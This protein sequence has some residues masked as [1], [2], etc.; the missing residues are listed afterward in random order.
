[1]TID[2]HHHFWSVARGDYDWLADA[3]AALRRNFLP[4]DVRAQH[5]ALGIT[6]SVL[7]QAAPTL[8]ET[9]YLLALAAAVPTVCGVVGWIDMQSG[10]ALRQ[11][12][13]FAAD[14][15]FRGIRPML[16]DLADLDW[17]ASEALQP[18]MAALIDRDLSFDA[19]VRADQFDTVAALATAY[20]ELR[21]ILD[22][23]GKPPIASGAPSAWRAALARL[24]TCPNVTCKLSGL[25]TE[26]AVGTTLDDLAP[27]AEAML[28]LFGTN[29]VMW[30]SDW[31]MLT[32]R[33]SVRDWHDWCH[34]LVMP[35]GVAAVRDVFAGTAIRVYRL[36]E[37][38][39]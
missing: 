27:Y 9:R 19:L 12:R 2:A 8:A 37:Q 11:L 13:D 18:L 6:G 25:I 34:A 30:G 32:P 17:L 24:A 39:Q 31:P 14:P 16:Q 33:T 5:D 7:V 3:P 36:G 4:G 26:A 38:A 1:V 35:H 10:D 28:A 20:P 15:L 29:R 23:G 22:H 21:I